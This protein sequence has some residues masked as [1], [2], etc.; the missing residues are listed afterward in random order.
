MMIWIKAH[1][2]QVLDKRCTVFYLRRNDHDFK[3]ARDKDQISR[4]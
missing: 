4:G 3:S 2:C 1:A